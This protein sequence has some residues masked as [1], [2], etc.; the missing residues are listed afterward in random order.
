MP[1]AFTFPEDY[2]PQKCAIVAVPVALMPFVA[3]AVNNLKSRELWDTLDDWKAAYDAFSVVE[4]FI[5]QNCAAD[6]TT[7]L[8]RLYRLMESVYYGTVWTATGDPPVITPDIPT[9]PPAG[10]LPEGLIART[11]YIQQVLD[12]ALNGTYY[13]LFNIETSLRDQLQAIIDGIAADGEVEAEE[14]AKLVEILAA[15]A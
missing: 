5:M 11:E 3:G 1:S 8:D 9:V 2:D 14:L 10:S 6:L 15:L 4:A 13:P 7:G 12:N